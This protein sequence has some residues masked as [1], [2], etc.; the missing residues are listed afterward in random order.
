VLNVVF[1]TEKFYAAYCD[2]PEIEQKDTRPYIR[3][4]VLVNN[5]LWA[6]PLRSHIRHNY[7]IWTD[8]EKGCGLDFSKA[9]VVEKPDEYISGDKPYVRP[10]E[11]KVIK[12]IDNYTV[13]RKLQQYIK[14]Y[15]DAKDHLE[16]NRNK[17]IVRCSTLQYFE[18]YL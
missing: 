6:I 18:K 8:K 11:F 14:T 13:T 5:V 10:E 17:Q 9:V 1:L 16:I 12:R 15:K 4:Q 7:A 2:C 3:V